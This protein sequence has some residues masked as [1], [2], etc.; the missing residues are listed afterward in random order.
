MVPLADWLDGSQLFNSLPVLSLCPSGA[1][2]EEVNKHWDWL[3]HNLLHSLSV[4]E[5]KEDVASFV[6]GKVKVGNLPVLQRM[7]LVFEMRSVK[8]FPVHLKGFKA[9]IG[10]K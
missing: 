9:F 3:V 4:F 10:S 6:K 8:D 7:S 1:A 5:N 2:I